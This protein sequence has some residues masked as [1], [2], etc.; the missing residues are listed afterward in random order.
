MGFFP[1]PEP[2]ESGTQN[3]AVPAQPEWQRSPDDELPGIVP[4]AAVLASTSELAITL[5]GVE[6]Y[7][8]GAVF[9]LGWMLRR[10]DA[11]E[12][13]WAD[14]LVKLDGPRYWG[15]RDFAS[16]L[17]LGVGLSDGQQVVAGAETWWDK[18]EDWRPDGH[19]LSMF[20]QGGGGSDRSREYTGSLWLWP[21]PPA[22]PVRLVCQ[23]AA[24]G[25]GESAV[26][27][28]GDAIRD[29]AARA[30]PIWP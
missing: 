21:L 23:W 18:G 8:N 15:R 9:R 30:R 27:V 19:I 12:G 24:F 3:A 16:E 6:A 11:D 2:E 26:E 29:A 10:G 25:I 7:S 17:R 4:A 14:L 1:E 22:G 20:E 28:S 13:E 5:R